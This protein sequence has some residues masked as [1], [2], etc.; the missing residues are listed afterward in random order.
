MN[1]F[2]HVKQL[3]PLVLTPFVLTTAEE[4]AFRFIGEEFEV[5][6]AQ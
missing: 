2:I 3:K 4:A 1:D 6:G 5:K